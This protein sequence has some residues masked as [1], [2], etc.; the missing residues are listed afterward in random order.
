MQLVDSNKGKATETQQR[1]NGVR[2]KRRR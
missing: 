1:S 2:S